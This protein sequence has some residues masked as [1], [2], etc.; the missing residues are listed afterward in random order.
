MFRKFIKYH[1]ILI[2]GQEVWGR[3]LAWDDNKILVSRDDGGNPLERVLI[4]RQAIALSEPL[5]S[6]PVR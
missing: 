2:T 5:A 4:Y 1:F 3:V 6:A